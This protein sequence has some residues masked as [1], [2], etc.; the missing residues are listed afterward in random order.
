MFVFSILNNE[1]AASIELT[2]DKDLILD[3]VEL[4]VDNNAQVETFEMTLISESEA[5]YFYTL[6][7]LQPIP[8]QAKLQ[9]IL[10]QAAPFDYPITLQTLVFQGGNA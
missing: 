7:L 4:I 3:K 6:A 10:T 1:D 9:I 8:L 5:A 2:I